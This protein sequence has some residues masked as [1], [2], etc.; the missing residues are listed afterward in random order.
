MSDYIDRWKSLFQANRLHSGPECEAEIVRGQDT[1]QKLSVY[2]FYD[3]SAL[4]NWT[5]RVPDC[6]YMSSD[7]HAIH[8]LPN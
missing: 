8:I 1:R 4:S 5:F 3:K 6:M 7:T 2:V